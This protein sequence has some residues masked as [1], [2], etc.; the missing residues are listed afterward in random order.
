MISSNLQ[1]TKQCKSTL[2]SSPMPTL[3]LGLLRSSC[4]GQNAVAL[5]PLREATFS[6]LN[7]FSKLDNITV[8]PSKGGGTPQRPTASL[9]VEGV[10]GKPEGKGFY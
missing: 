8:A 6:L 3:R 7:A 1:P 5:F 9:L 4:A 10:L 2:P